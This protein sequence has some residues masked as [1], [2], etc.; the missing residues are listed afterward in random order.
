MSNFKKARESKCLSQKEI[1]ITLKVSQPTVS[2]WES[3][4]K[5]PAGKNLKRLMELLDCSAD[6][7]LELT[8]IPTPPEIKRDPLDGLKFA[9]W[10]HGDVSDEALEDVRRFAEFI[11]LREREKEKQSDENN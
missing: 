7:L 3:G 11:E 9:L 8:D 4:K 6:Y 1:A 2:E 10:G 5:T